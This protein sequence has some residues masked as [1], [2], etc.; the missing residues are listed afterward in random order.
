MLYY[1][2]IDCH[3]TYLLPV[4]GS[5]P[6]TYIY[7]LKVLQN[8]FVKIIFIK[9]F[10][11]PS[12]LLYSKKLRSLNKNIHYEFILYIYKILNNQIK[13]NNHLITYITDSNVRTRNADTLRPPNFK[14][15]LAQS[16][17]F[18]RGLN[19]YNSLPIKVKNLT[20]LS[21]FKIELRK[22]ISNNYPI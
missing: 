9:P 21:L 20:Q 22:Y 14:G 6:D 16:T 2:Y 17:I 12:T 18:Y 11:T 8:K 10:L 4:W 5:A 13:W 15:A 3:F 19:L 7:T 1:A